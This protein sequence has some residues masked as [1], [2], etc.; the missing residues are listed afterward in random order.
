M[1]KLMMSL[2]VMA[3][4]SVNAYAL[5]GTVTV[6]QAL[7]DGTLKVK[8]TDGT[9]TQLKLLVGTPDAVKAMYAAALTAKSTGSEVYA[10]PGTYDSVDGWVLFSVQ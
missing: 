8:V 2:I 4:I 6:V 1:K 3:A 5:T 7:S 9:V 10:K